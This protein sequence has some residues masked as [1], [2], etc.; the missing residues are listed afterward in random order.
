MLRDMR[1]RGNLDRRP[2][3]LSDGPRW[4]PFGLGDASSVAVPFKRDD[5]GTAWCTRRSMR[6]MAVASLGKM[7]GQSLNGKFV[8]RMWV[9]EILAVGFR[10]FWPVPRMMTPGLG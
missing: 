10:K 7:V 2:T 6:A 1:K 8:M 5:L 3:Q 9:P 4:L